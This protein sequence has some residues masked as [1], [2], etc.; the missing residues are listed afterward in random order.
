[1]AGAFDFVPAVVGVLGDGEG[2][3]DSFA[4]PGL[5][6]DGVLDA[7]DDDPDVGL[8]AAALGRQSDGVSRFG[9]PWGDLNVTFAARERA[10]WRGKAEGGGS[11][12]CGE[13]NE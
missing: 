5:Q 6:F 12:E 10:N 4:G 3:G 2:A 9:D 7:V 11:G 1:V 8:A 13:G